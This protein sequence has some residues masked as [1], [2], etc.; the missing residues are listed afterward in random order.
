MSSFPHTFLWGGATAANQC[1]GAYD[2]DGKGLSVQD[3]MPKGVHGNVT[4]EPTDDNL[5]LI[6]IDFYHRYEE[7]IKLFSMMGFKVFRMS[8]AWTRI[9]PTGEENEPNEKGLEFYDRVFDT[10]RKYGIEPLVTLSHY[11]PPLNLAKKYDGWRNRKLIHLF[12]KYARVVFERYKD[13]VKYWLTF[14]E[15][16]VTIVSP[17]LGGGILTP[18]EDVSLSD[19]Y[20]AA[21]HQLVASSLVTKLA[22]EINSECKIGCMVASQPCYPMTCNPDDVL[23]AMEL[24]QETTFFVHI[25]ATGKYPYYTKRL[26]RE[27]E[28]E[29]DITKE[30][31]E[32]LKHTVDFISFSYYNS[33]T[34]AKDPSSYELAA[35]N[36]YRGLKNPYLKY[37]EWNYP[38]D[39]QGLRYILNFYYERYQLPLFVSENGMGYHDNPDKNQDGTLSIEDDYRID[40][41]REHLLQVE[42]AIEDG[43]DVFGYTAWGCIDLVSAAS[44]QI[45]KRYGFIYV[46]RHSDGSGSLSRYPKKSFYWYKD[47]IAS[48]GDI[49]KDEIS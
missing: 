37:S 14:N 49:L 10:C 32:I 3:V 44:A 21:H 43:V 27:L 16:N 36:I 34:M 25:H 47:V 7:D 11:E 33:R 1:E 13:K 20:Q 24:Q 23:Y 19:R 2:V 17:L 18:K 28:V 38:I 35:G 42:K 48:N 4:K 39:S 46:D 45:D 31:K 29:I 22:K 40:F 12:E 30:D 26:F 5:K 9:F 8:I 15:I 6:G 41:F